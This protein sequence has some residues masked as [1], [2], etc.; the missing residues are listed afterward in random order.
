VKEV[1]EIIDSFPAT[2]AACLHSVRQTLLALV[3]G[4]VEDTT[5]GMPTLRVDNKVLLSFR[6]FSHHNS[7]FPGREVQDLLGS[8]LLPYTTTKGTIHCDIHTPPPKT[9]VKAV[10]A[11][12]IRV[13]NTSFPKQS[14]EFL[15]FY[16]T[17]FVKGRCRYTN[18]QMHGAWE[19][20]RKDGTPLRSGSFRLGVQTGPWITYS[21]DGSPY[22]TTNV[23]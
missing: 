1:P 17:G 12:R 2:Q 23:T 5:W 18:D 20:F 15:S 3:P 16:S 11:A 8:A 10:V 14:G 13:I 19:F 21:P 22:K 6:G 7:L 9:F 4:A